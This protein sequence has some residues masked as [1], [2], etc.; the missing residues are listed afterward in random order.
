M[1]QKWSNILQQSEY[2][3]LTLC[4]FWYIWRIMWRPHEKIHLIHLEE[5]I[6]HS[7][8]E[9]IIKLKSSETRT[10]FNAFPG[11]VSYAVYMAF[12]ECFPG[13]K[14]SIN[15]EFSM[16]ITEIVNGLFSGTIL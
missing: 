4:I 12:Y 13:S 9:I 16:K 1:P 7:Y 6:S 15:T 8:V 14:S 3:R 10:L 11:I 5:L 2:S